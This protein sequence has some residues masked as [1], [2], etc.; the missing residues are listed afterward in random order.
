VHDD[1]KVQL[2][3]TEI[4]VSWEIDIVDILGRN[5][6]GVINEKDN[7]LFHFSIDDLE[8]CGLH[9]IVLK[10]DGAVADVKPIIIH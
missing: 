8:A 2:V 10:K 1:V 5:V 4:N 3:T 7:G 9:W 6:D